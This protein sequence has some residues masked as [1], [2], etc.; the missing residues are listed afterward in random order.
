VQSRGACFFVVHCI[1]DNVQDVCRLLVVLHSKNLDLSGTLKV[2][3]INISGQFSIL[4]FSCSLCQLTGVL[5]SIGKFGPVMC[6]DTYED[7]KR[8]VSAIKEN[9]KGSQKQHNTP[10]TT[11]ITI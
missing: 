8:S 7:L 11:P 6:I 10:N 2:E 1:I 9:L 4:D 5:L 3:C